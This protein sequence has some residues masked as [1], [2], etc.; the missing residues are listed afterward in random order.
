M[1][2]ATADIATTGDD[3][4]AGVRDLIAPVAGRDGWRLRAR[5]PWWLVLPPGH[6]PR[7]QGWKLH[8]S[9]TVGDAAAVLRAA[10]GVLIDEGCAFKFA[11]TLRTVRLI[12]GRGAD[13]SSAGKFL[14]AYPDDDDQFRRLAAHLHAVTG[15]LAGPVILSDRPYRPGSLVHYRFGGFHSRS[16]LDN[17]GTYRPVLTAPDG[18]V[19]EDRREARFAPPA[20]ATAPLPD[21]PPRPPATAAGSD[22]GPL[23][24]PLS[25]RFSGRFRGSDRIGGR[26]VLLGGRFVVR[27]AIRHSTK[28]GVFLA[29]DTLASPEPGS[30]AGPDRVAGTVVIKQARP[31]TECDGTGQDSRD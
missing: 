12:D 26:A 30:P 16:V 5:G 31:H 10:A 29:E 18:T 13:R 19:V 4:V 1:T 20:W 9:A 8:L 11:A 25:G 21:P 14:T 17:D 3:L 22:R 15:G 24:G 27:E 7:E 2:T 28:G 6:R 23:G